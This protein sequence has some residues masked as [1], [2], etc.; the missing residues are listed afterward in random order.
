M[1]TRWPRVSSTLQDRADRRPHLTL[2][3]TAGLAVVEYVSWFNNERLHES[4][5]DISPA[6][7][8][9]LYAEPEEQRVSLKMKIGSH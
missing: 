7:F 5:S 3:L 2:S 8:E 1:T 9:S 6:E 4:L